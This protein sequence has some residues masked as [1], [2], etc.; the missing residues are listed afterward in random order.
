MIEGGR[1]DHAAHRNDAVAAIRDVLAFDDA[2]GVAMDFARRHP[3]TLVL[4]TAD[5]ETGGMAIIGGS[6]ASK[7]YVGADFKAIE[8]VRSSF[9][10]LLKDLGPKPGAEEIKAAVENTWRSN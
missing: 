7:E 1:I 4:V 3:E 9:E 10:V 8:R 6:K 5:H 2:V